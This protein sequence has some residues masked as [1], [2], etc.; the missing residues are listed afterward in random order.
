M[1]LYWRGID[2]NVI[3]Y[4]SYSGLSGSQ[5]L[6]SNPWLSWTHLMVIA[7]PEQISAKD[8][9]SL[10]F[11]APRSR[12]GLIPTTITH[13]GLTRFLFPIRVV[14]VGACIQSFKTLTSSAAGRPSVA[15][16]N[17]SNR[18]PLRGLYP[19]ITKHR[20]FRSKRWYWSRATSWTMHKFAHSNHFRNSSGKPGT[21]SVCL[22]H[23]S[24]RRLNLIC[25]RPT[26]RYDVVVPAKVLSQ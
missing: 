10:L 8:Y 12:R 6:E 20:L 23:R 17:V 25:D 5:S 15:L 7:R 13:K 4:I 19:R 26:V 22:G 14:C 24:T 11:A 1:R 16:R 9:A 3:V 18:R 21:R 2:R